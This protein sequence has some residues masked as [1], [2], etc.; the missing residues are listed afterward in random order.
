MIKK[1]ISMGW[2]DLFKILQIIRFPTM[3]WKKKSKLKIL[4]DN[5]DVG[6]WSIDVQKGR[7][8]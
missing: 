6:I 1:E 3:Y 2:L 8:C 5:P 7:L 4:Y